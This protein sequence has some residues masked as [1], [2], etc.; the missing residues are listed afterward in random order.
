MCG[1]KK[2]RGYSLTSD[3]A[4]IIRLIW[5]VR[6]YIHIS[7][8]F[9]TPFSNISKAAR[10]GEGV[11]WG[12]FSPFAP[13]AK[14]TYSLWIYCCYRCSLYLLL[15]ARK[16]IAKGFFARTRARPVSTTRKCIKINT[17]YLYITRC[18]N[19]GKSEWKLSPPSAIQWYFTRFNPCQLKFDIEFFNSFLAEHFIFTPLFIYTFTCSKCTCILLLRFIIV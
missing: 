17:S 10:S 1:L 16:N 9:L 8:R 3:C 5:Q 19:D 2:K 4:Y 18:F 15:P 12:S 13:R 14:I 6:S 11:V 7:N